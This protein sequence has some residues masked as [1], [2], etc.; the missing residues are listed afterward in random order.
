V[1]QQNSILFG[2]TLQYLVLLGV[3]Y[4]IWYCFFFR[5]ILFLDNAQMCPNVQGWIK[6]VQNEKKVISSYLVS[7]KKKEQKK[8][9]KKTQIT[10]ARDAS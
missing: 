5:S 10:G 4:N 3:L 6:E 1:H 7:K 9:K 2:A 8:R